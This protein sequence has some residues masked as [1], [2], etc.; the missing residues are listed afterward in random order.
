MGNEGL[1]KECGRLMV[2]CRRLS[3]DGV[4]RSGIWAM[5]LCARN[6]WQCGDTMMG[7]ERV[8]TE[9]RGGG[10]ERGSDGVME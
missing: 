5:R 2:G 10:R 1:G 8:S 6:V 4:A 7:N 3:K 9:G